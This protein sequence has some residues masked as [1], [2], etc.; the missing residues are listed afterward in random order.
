[1]SAHFRKKSI[2][3]ASVMFNLIILAINSMAYAQTYYYVVDKGVTSEYDMS[4]PGGQII[5]R[6]PANDVFSPTQTI[7]F[8][9][10]FFGETVVQFKASDNGY[11][12]FDLNAAKSES[13]NEAIPTSTAPNKSIYAFW[14]NLELSNNPTFM[15]NDIKTYT[16]G[17]APNRVFVVQ[18][19]CTPLGKT[20]NGNYLFFAI[21][22]YEGA[23][24]DVIFQQIRLDGGVSVSGTVG[25]EN[26]DGSVATMVSGSPNFKYTGGAY[27]KE[28]V[29]V[30]RFMFGSKPQYDA[31]LKSIDLPSLVAI[32]KSYDVGASIVNHG[33][34]SISSVGL[35]YQV[36]SGAVQST[37]I[38]GL[39]IPTNQMTSIVHPVR[40][41]PTTAGVF[42]NVKVWT[43]KINGNADQFS[44]DDTLMH[45][46][47]VNLG[48]TTK[49]KVLI[50]E[51]STAPCGYCPEGHIVLEDILSKY[52]DVIGVTHH[53]GYQTDSMTITAG[54][55]IA[56]AFANGAPTA[57]IDRILFPNTIRVAISRTDWERRAVEQLAVPSPVSLALKTNFQPVTR[58]LQVSVD[59]SFIDY[60]YP[61]DMR[62]TV[63]IIEDH[64]IG[65]G[66]GYDQT[67]YF[68]DQLGHPLFQKGDP[69]IGY[70]HRRVVRAV[71]PNAW[72][73]PNLIQSN[74]GPG[75]KYSK[76]FSYII[77]ARFK[78]SDIS[79]I[80][81]VSYVESGK[82]HLL[83]AEIQS[84]IVSWIIVKP[85]PLRWMLK[86]YPNPVMR[87]AIVQYGLKQTSFVQLE[88]INALGEVVRTIVRDTRRAGEYEAK[89][90]AHSLPAGMYFLHLR[91][92]G[93][94]RFEKVFIMK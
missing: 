40:W 66:K 53:S 29:P 32:N 63:C 77:P 25:C 26:A 87:S 21:R 68:N 78:E 70:D 50:E 36:G 15:T 39:N 1:M 33:E 89:L 12:T 3:A 83:N 69:I 45:R 18:W 65:S 67:N 61:G 93:I 54:E 19:H 9:W 6:S 24:F 31:L 14:D 20:A 2:I 57:C 4:A 76:S 84:S 52:A 90:D 92:G 28:N 51:F 47:F 81:F 88:L 37:T 74:V 91:T 41:S 7:P 49:K 71:L 43:G 42:E 85:I 38:T 62:L 27:I 56:D 80:A 75:G 44:S 17:S 11:I 94:S 82:H 58:E 23:D 64:V 79:V 10:K 73:E 8:S 60:P 59:L 48:L 13:N 35:N 30:Y 16:V 22:L 5:L 34:Q 86:V 55:Q 72:G 46:A